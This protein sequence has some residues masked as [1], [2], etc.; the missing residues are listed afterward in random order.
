MRRISSRSV[1]EVEA[2]HRARPS[3]ERNEAGAQAQQRGLAGPVG[4][5][6]QED[7]AFVD[8]QRRPGQR[9]ERSEHGNRLIELHD[10]HRHGR[11][12]RAERFERRD[13]VRSAGR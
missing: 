9:G 1:V 8:T 5:S 11:H 12:A 3:G 13:R 10:R 7:L 4:P 2:E 6:Q